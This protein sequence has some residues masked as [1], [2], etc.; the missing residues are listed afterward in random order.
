MHIGQYIE[1]YRICKTLGLGKVFL[2][3]IGTK[4]VVLKPQLWERTYELEALRAVQ[5]PNV[6]KL[7]DVA[8]AQE[9]PQGARPARHALFAV[10]RYIPGQSIAGS[11]I[12]SKYLPERVSRIGSQVADA[13][14]H[15]HEQGFVHN[16]VTSRN[17]MAQQNTLIDFGSALPVDETHG[18]MLRISSTPRYRCLDQ[19]F[20]HNAPSNDVFGLGAVLWELC[21]QENLDVQARE[22]GAMAETLAFMRMPRMT[23]LRDAQLRSLI[24]AMVEVD[25]ANRPAMYEVA[26]T[27]GKYDA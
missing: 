21:K 9:A 8:Y 15:T 4:R 25:A 27:L 11:N 3:N 19:M 18:D 24:T 14:Q 1:K 23:Q 12:S 20:H 10:L 17:V 6:V 7:E 26:R 13:L 2:A 22:E 16:D 5:H